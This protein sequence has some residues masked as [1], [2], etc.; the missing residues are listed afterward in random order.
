MRLSFHSYDVVKVMDSF[1]ILM[2]RFNFQVDLCLVFLKC[3]LLIVIEVELARQWHDLADVFH[4]YDLQNVHE[5]IDVV[6]LDQVQVLDLDLFLLDEVFHRNCELFEGLLPF[7]DSSL[8]DCVCH[9]CGLSHDII[10][11]FAP[12]HSIRVQQWS[13]NV[14]V[15]QRRFPF[16]YLKS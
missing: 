11:K 15:V 10:R 14:L 5:R 2:N 7:F 3:S 1:G 13:V 12:H 6:F 9:D 4:R 16:E 8:D